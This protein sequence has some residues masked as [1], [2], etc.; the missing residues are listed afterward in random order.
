M[1]LHQTAIHLLDRQT[2]LPRRHTGDQKAYE[3]VNGLSGDKI[4]SKLK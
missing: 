2:V 1:K 4:K 3:K